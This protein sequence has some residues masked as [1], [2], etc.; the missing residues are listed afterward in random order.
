M[1]PPNF[2]AAR[3]ILLSSQPLA[4]TSSNACPSLFSRRNSVPYKFLLWFRVESTDFLKCI[5]LPLSSTNHF[6]H[7]SFVNVNQ[8]N[9][10]FWGWI[11]DKADPHDVLLGLWVPSQ[12]QAHLT[13]GW[14][15]LK[16]PRD[17]CPEIWPHGWP[18]DGDTETPLEFSLF[19]ACSWVSNLTILN[20]SLLMWEMEIIIVPVW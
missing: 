3:P 5:V 6:P 16:G 10:K 17:L 4:H 2:N 11:T 9:I 8:K 7:W 13:P 20:L 15:R 18:C 14:L 19:A 12:V 1:P